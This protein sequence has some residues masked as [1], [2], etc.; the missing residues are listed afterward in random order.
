[1]AWNFCMRVC[2]Y[3]AT[4][5]GNSLCIVIAPTPGAAERIFKMEFG[6]YLDLGAV[7]F[8]SEPTGDDAAYLKHVPEP[9][10][11]MAAKIPG[12]VYHSSWNYNL[13]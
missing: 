12:F 2:H 11:K 9:V 4:G 10:L 13:S 3:A 5:E 8:T 1:M 6:D 7:D